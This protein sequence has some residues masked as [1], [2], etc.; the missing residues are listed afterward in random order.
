[1]RIPSGRRVARDRPEMGERRADGLAVRSQP[2][3]LGDDQRREEG[4]QGDQ[5]GIQPVREG[6][7]RGGRVE[8]GDGVE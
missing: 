7:L 6:V 5:R 3:R 8:V 4:G 1:M 2:E